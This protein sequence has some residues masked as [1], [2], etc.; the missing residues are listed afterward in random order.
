M[1]LAFSQREPNAWMPQD[2]DVKW[3]RCLPRYEVFSHFLFSLTDTSGLDLLDAT[4]VGSD[5]SV[6]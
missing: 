6:S 1:N 3:S 4:L 5:L 2:S